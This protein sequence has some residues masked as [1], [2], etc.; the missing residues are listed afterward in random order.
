MQLE[1]LESAQT[2]LYLQLVKHK[3]DFRMDGTAELTINYRARYNNQSREYDILSVDLEDLNANI[4]NIQEQMKDLEGTKSAATKKFNEQ[5]KTT[6]GQ[7]NAILADRYTYVMQAVAA[8]IK[9][10]PADPEALG[11]FDPGWAMGGVTAGARKK[12]LAEASRRAANASGRGTQ[13]RG[14]LSKEGIARA[15]GATTAIRTGAGSSSDVNIYEAGRQA[16]VE[17]NASVQA[18]RRLLEEA[19]KENS[20]LNNVVEGGSLSAAAKNDP[21]ATL[22]AI[23]QASEGDDP[24]KADAAKKFLKPLGDQFGDY[25]GKATNIL[26]PPSSL[27]VDDASADTTGAISEYGYLFAH[28]TGNPDSKKMVMSAVEKTNKQSSMGI[29][30]KTGPGVVAGMA[31]SATKPGTVQI[32]FLFLGDIIDA[33]ILGPSSGT[34]AG[35]SGILD[36]LNSRQVGMITL[37]VQQVDPYAV[38]RKVALQTAQIMVASGNTNVGEQVS[39]NMWGCGLDALTH[40]EK[41]NFMKRINIANIPVHYDLFYAWFVDKVVTPAREVYY[42]ETFLADLLQQFV[43]PALSNKTLPKAPPSQVTIGYTRLQMD[44]KQP[45]TEKS[46]ELPAAP[47]GGKGNNGFEIGY[48]IDK[49]MIPFL[50]TSTGNPFPNIGT[51]VVH[52]EFKVL[53]MT[54]MNAATA[55]GD[56]DLDAAMG[57][58]HFTIGADRG[59]LKSATFNRADMPYLGEARVDRT[60]FA[61]AEQLRD[62]YHVNLK[63][64]GTTLIKP[65]QFIYIAP[66]QLTFGDPSE[67]N[68]LARILGMGGYHLVVDVSSEITEDGYETTIKALHQAMTA[69]NKL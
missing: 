24:E 33:V 49:Q 54:S 14:W 35:V 2:S 59:I 57:I 66:N 1:A 17:M 25:F 18:Y 7:K 15:F 8:H 31:V 61:G 53:H 65:G 67:R 36:L 62:I 23:V 4:K 41:V 22:A 40:Q 63:L 26:N 46:Y 13:D 42:F 52:T 64:Y 37:D 6:E 29:L 55:I 20:D 9:Q 45:F 11:L 69:I 43:K 28:Q 39:E 60:R 48:L 58:Y 47:K 21:Q 56:P 32:P 38:M 27:K 5:I 16:E 30:A 34:G 68:S 3:F 50:E 19:K 51:G 12:Q 10:V 44:A